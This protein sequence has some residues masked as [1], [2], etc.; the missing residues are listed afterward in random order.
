MVTVVIIVA[1]LSL[2][3]IVIG[4]PAL[5]FERTRVWGKKTAIRS[6]VAFFISL[7]LV[8]WASER[9]A[10]QAGFE[11]V[12][13]KEIAE[14]AGYTDAAKWAMVRDVE[15]EKIRTAKRAEED[16]INA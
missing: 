6:T 2:L 9:E 4:A 11:S 14:K 7:F 16:R 13:D 15:M 3:G 5:L 10:R 1:L 12:N 8:G